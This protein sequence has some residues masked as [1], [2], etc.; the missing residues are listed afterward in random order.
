M[1]AVCLAYN[2]SVLDSQRYWNW[3]STKQR[4]GLGVPNGFPDGL[5]SPLAW[6]GEEILTKE[7]ECMFDLSEEDVAAIDNAVR[8]FDGKTFF[9]L[10]DEARPYRR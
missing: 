10:D 7:S 1:A 3:Q 9:H 4:T 8:A 6:T 5:Y 2:P